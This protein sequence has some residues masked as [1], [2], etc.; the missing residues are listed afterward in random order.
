MNNV[1][2]KPDVNGVLSNMVDMSHEKVIFYNHKDTGLKVILAIHN[3]VLG[4]ALGGTRILHYSNE[5]D[6]LNDVL[7]LS[8]GMTYKSSLAGLD[9]GGGKAVIIG[10]PSIVKT[11]AFLRSYGRFVDS[12]GGKYITAE[13]VNTT[14]H[15]VVTIAKETKYVTGLPESHGG[16]GDPSLIT[17]Y[18]VYMGIKAGVKFAKGTD[19]LKNIKIG[20]QGVGK[21]GSILVKYLCN[22]GATVLVTDV[23]DD[24][25]K[26]VASNYNVKVVPIDDFYDADMD[27]Y[28]PC[29]LGG[30][31]NDNNIMSLKCTIV[32]GAANNQLDDANRHSKQLM[33][34]GIV[35]LP[36]FVINAGGVINAYAEFIGDSDSKRVKY[37]TEKIYTTCLNILRESIRRSISTNDIAMEMA[38]RRINDIKNANLSYRLSYD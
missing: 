5:A 14:V 35:Y 8:S 24:S 34:K 37:D 33:N 27:V 10:D 7:R 20:V 11:E 16:N 38:S 4:P 31:L 23:S 1:E 22:D 32:A 29:A 26:Y 13:D 19:S 15:D 3:T 36:D 17:A 9:I 18:G 21:V 28:A 30:T 6:A 12:L 2:G 25:L